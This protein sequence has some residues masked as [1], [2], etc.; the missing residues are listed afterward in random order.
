MLDHLPDRAQIK[1]GG[2]SSSSLVG[3]RHLGLLEQGEVPTSGWGEHRRQ[4]RPLR[5]AEVV[6]AN[7][8]WNKKDNLVSSLMAVIKYTFRSN[9]REKGFIL[10]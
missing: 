9:L 8:T 2:D 5:A 1:Q 6:A 3:I 4:D 10:T 7:A